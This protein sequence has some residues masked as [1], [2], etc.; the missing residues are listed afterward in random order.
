[1]YQALIDMTTFSLIMTILVL[2]LAKLAQLQQM[3][4]MPYATPGGSILPGLYW[5]RLRTMRQLE[6]MKGWN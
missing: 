1:M 3:V 6:N 2:I 5:E 4:S